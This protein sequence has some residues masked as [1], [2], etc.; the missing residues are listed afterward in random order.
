MDARHQID[1]PIISPTNR[2]S[3]NATMHRKN[4]I[5]A[6]PAV[7]A[8]MPVNPNNAATSDT[9]KKNKASLSIT[10]SGAMLMG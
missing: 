6:M 8:E 10:V 9:T 2:K 7:A 5:L 1:A 3:R 4:R